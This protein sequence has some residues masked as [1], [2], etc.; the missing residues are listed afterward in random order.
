MAVALTEFGGYKRRQYG[1]SG[2]AEL[3]RL[4]GRFGGTEEG[5]PRPHQLSGA[6]SPPVGPQT[7]ELR[8]TREQGKLPLRR[9]AAPDDA[10]CGARGDPRIDRKGFLAYGFESVVGL[11]NLFRDRK[12]VGCMACRRRRS[13]PQLPSQERSG[14]GRGRQSTGEDL[15]AQCAGRDT[16]QCLCLACWD[17][18]PNTSQSCTG[19]PGSWTWKVSP[20]IRPDWMTGPC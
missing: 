2:A 18:S 5:K 15:D 4:V 6:Q 16:G 13:D 1:P 14:V 19:R 3:H 10:S 20:V 7:T 9:S 8:S 11:L 17:L 12:R